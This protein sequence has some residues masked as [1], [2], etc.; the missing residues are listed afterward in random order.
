MLRT[1][2][3]TRTDNQALR[4]L[5]IAVFVLLMA[6]SAKISFNFGAIPFTMQV[7]VVLLSGMVLGSRDGTASQLSYLG[8]I[9]AGLPID[10]RGLGTAVFASPSWGY[11]VG[12][13]V[14]A[15]VAG[16]L[17]EHGA[18]KVWQRWLAG[19]LGIL[20]IYAF[21]IPVLK[22]MLNMDWQAAWTA[23]AVPFFALDLAKALLAALMVEGGRSLLLRNSTLVEEKPKN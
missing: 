19:V 5:G 2:Q 15:F 1:I 12:F 18:E 7:F 14:A 3:L 4:L 10:A 9:A 20:I 6:L 16:W 23:G 8:L 22:M 11:L 21:G 13:V 17:A